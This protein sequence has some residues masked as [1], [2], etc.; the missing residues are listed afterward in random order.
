MRMYEAVRPLLTEV[1][2]LRMTARAQ[3][4][5]VSTTSSEL[6]Q[7]KKVTLASW[8]VNNTAVYCILTMCDCEVGFKKNEQHF[9]YSSMSMLSRHGYIIVN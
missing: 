5:Q 9:S 2:Q 3:D 4:D 1:E 7:L 8:V 6:L